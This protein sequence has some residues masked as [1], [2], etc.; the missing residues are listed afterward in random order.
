MKRIKS[1]YKLIASTLVAIM[2]TVFCAPALTVEASYWRHHSYYHHDRHHHWSSKDTWIAVGGIAL[3]AA[4]SNSS[5]HTS[6]TYSEKFAGIVDGFKPE[7][8]QIYRALDYLPKG[9]VQTIQYFNEKD[10]TLVKN[11]IR[12]LYGEYIYL[13]T[14]SHD[15]VNWVLFYKFSIIYQ[16]KQVNGNY[17]NFVARDLMANLPYGRHVLP[18]E[19]KLAKSILTCIKYCYPKSHGYREGD[20]FIIEK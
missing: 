11:V 18:Y 17:E 16:S 1:F 12:K 10:L 14:F 5:S 20:Y 6:K 19:S 3:L 4:L 8:Q 2:F 15:N 7:E 13:T 9:K